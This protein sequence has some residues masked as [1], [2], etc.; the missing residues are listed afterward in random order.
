[1][2]QNPDI[3]ARQFAEERPGLLGFI[4]RRVSDQDQAE[5]ILQ[6]AFERATRSLNE[7]SVSSI[8]AL[9]YVIARNLI[10]DH[11]RQTGFRSQFWVDD[12]DVESEYRNEG[13]PERHAIAEERLAT[14]REVVMA[15]PEK[16]RRAF[17]EHRFEHRS[18]EHIAQDMALSKSMVKKYI[19]KAILEIHSEIKRRE[20]D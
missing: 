2:S 18:V 10:T 16:C 13:D 8:R 20:G 15:L 11:Y 4:L 14:V 5:V 6:V 1:M 17:V 19:Q 7:K 3:V 12:H 9:L